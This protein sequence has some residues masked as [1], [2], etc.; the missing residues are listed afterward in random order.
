MALLVY[1]KNDFET[2]HEMDQYFTLCGKL[3]EYYGSK[4]EL[5]VFI[6]NYSIGGCS[7]DGFI[8]K[9]TGFA[10]IEFKS[11]GGEIIAVENGP[12]IS[13]GKEIKGG[14]PGKNVLEQIKINRSGVRNFLRSLNILPEENKMDLGGIVV[15][16]EIIKLDNR[17]SS[18]SINLWLKI[19]DNNTFVQNVRVTKGRNI[20]FSTNEVLNIVSLLGLSYNDID[21]EYCA[22]P[23]TVEEKN[24]ESILYEDKEPIVSPKQIEEDETVDTNTT[25]VKR[26]DS[27]SLSDIKSVFQAELK[28]AVKEAIKDL[29]LSQI[30][31]DEIEKVISVPK[32]VD[33]AESPKSILSLAVNILT[34]TETE[35]YTY[36]ADRIQQS[37]DNEGIVLYNGNDE[38]IEVPLIACMAQVYPSFVRDSAEWVEEFYGWTNSNRTIVIYFNRVSSDKREALLRQYFDEKTVECW[39][40]Y[41]VLFDSDETMAIRVEDSDGSW[42]EHI[43]SVC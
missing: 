31:D 18:S 17:I 35:S 15:F 3:K 28:A 4:E 12:W 24:E 16:N 26:L 36:M 19:C 7:L 20:S 25:D 37:I 40:C 9:Q 33:K 10:V 21:K 32:E 39:L 5:C 38:K 8:I 41:R 2:Q 6:G 1:L 11:H 27:L 22:F 13:N 42:H 34:D 43:I 14:A 23:E 30:S 29:R